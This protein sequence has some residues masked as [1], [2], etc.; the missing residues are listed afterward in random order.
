MIPTTTEIIPYTTAAEMAAT[1]K[2]S[3]DRLREAFREI[4]ESSDDLAR[5][6]GD[7]YRYRVEVRQFGSYNTV[8]ADTGAAIVEEMKR[9]AWAALIE[10]LQIRKLMSSKR[11]DEMNKALAIGERRSDKQELPEITEE[12]IF[13]VLG[14]FVASA[15]EFLAEAIHEEYDFWKPTNHDYKRN[16]EFAM[17]PKIIREWMV[18]KWSSSWNISYD[19]RA[20]V[21]SLDRI[22][23]ELDGAGIP[24][25]HRGP[26][27]DT[28]ERAP[29]DGRG[30]TDFFR[31]RCCK[32][33]NLHLEF[34]R[35][36]LLD[37]FNRIA[38]RSRLPQRDPITGKA[39]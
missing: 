39:R 32:N 18:E 2:R 33:R 5:I 17:Q 20:H 31:F 21:Q 19:R 9:A 8:D 11:Q 4:G 24:Q 12:S 15:E 22:F 26:L 37:E 23:H 28:I 13:Q 36:D 34:K 6:F 1:F 29:D 16:S 38:G 10:R 30:E 7:G 3:A 14:G 27:C 25:G 35:V